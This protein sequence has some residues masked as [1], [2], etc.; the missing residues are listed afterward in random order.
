MIART[1]L[2]KE[3]LISILGRMIVGRLLGRPLSGRSRRIFLSIIRI[4][5]RRMGKMDFDVYIVL[6]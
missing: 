5:S 1:L 3:P 6:L 4:I 2:R